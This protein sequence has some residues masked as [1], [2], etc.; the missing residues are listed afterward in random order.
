[1]RTRRIKDEHVLK[2]PSTAAFDNRRQCTASRHGAAGPRC[3]RLHRASA[4]H[5]RRCC[6]CS[7]RCASWFASAPSCRGSSRTR[8]ESESGNTPPCAAPRCLLPRQR[9]HVARPL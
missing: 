9:R 6:R 4:I 2:L 7:C 8:P 5:H 3:A 1:V